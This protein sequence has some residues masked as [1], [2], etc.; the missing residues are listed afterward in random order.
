[1][2]PRFFLPQ[3]LIFPL[4]LLIFSLRLLTILPLLISSPFPLPR[5]LN[6]PLLRQA[7]GS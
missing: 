2:L 1:M 5:L 4:H 6:L 7:A 3:F